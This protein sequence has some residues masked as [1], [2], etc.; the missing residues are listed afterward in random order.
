MKFI[1]R[2]FS[3][4]KP[5][6][7]E[8]SRMQPQL[9]PAVSQQF[10]LSQNGTRRELLQVVLRDTLNRQGIPSGW[11]AGEP[12]TTTSRDGSKGLHWRLVIKHWDERLVIHG[13]ALQ[14]ALV[15]RVMTFD[16][17]ASSWLNGVSWQFGMDDESACPPLPHPGSW[18]AQQQA[19]SGSDHADS[20][21]H[22]S[23]VAVSA[24][25]DHA[26]DDLDALLAIRDA[27]FK[28]HAS[29]EGASWPRTEPAKL[30]RDA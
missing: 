22:I 7:F 16:P 27:D 25:T 24:E 5:P 17:M 4:S 20:P 30:A 10:P 14:Q 21:L 26:K 12:L 15:K 9:A 6:A 11:L 8:A 1:Q 2:L 29:G 19:Q 13:V 28:K 18:T 23:G 3:G